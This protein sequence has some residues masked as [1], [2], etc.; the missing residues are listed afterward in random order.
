MFL[1]KNVHDSAQESTHDLNVTLEWCTCS[2]D[3]CLC[4]VCTAVI[5][6]RKRRRILHWMEAMRLQGMPLKFMLTMHPDINMD[7][8]RGI[9]FAGNAFS[10]FVVSPMVTSTFAHIPWQQIHDAMQKQEDQRKEDSDE[11]DGD[12]EDSDEEDDMNASEQEVSLFVQEESD[13]SYSE[14]SDGEEKDEKA[15]KSKGRGEKSTDGESDL[16]SSD[17]GNQQAGS[18]D[19]SWAE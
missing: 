14:S 3:L 13:D 7:Q 9:T 17:V 1:M 11:E 18:D 8:E 15:E 19:D 6:L 12:E 4:I 10:G 16:H 2:M 5:L